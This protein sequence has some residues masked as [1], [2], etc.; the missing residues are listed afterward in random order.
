MC[1]HH[2]AI[3]YT[4]A[5]SRTIGFEE[6]KPYAASCYADSNSTPSLSSIVQAST[7]KAVQSATTKVLSQLSCNAYT[8]G[9]CIQDAYKTANV[10]AASYCSRTKLLR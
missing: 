5:C 4:Q 8:A 2:G 6:V 7:S 1:A 9:Q 3:V 10:T